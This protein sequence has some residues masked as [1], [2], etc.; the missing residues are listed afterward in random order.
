MPNQ[1]GTK[2]SIANSDFSRLLRRKQSSRRHD[3]TFWHI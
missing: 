1:P 3:V 2:V